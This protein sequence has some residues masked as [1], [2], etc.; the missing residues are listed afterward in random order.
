MTTLDHFKEFIADEEATH[1]YANWARDN[2]G[3]SAYSIASPSSSSE[4]GRWLTFKA[5]VL[6]GKRPTPPSLGSSQGQSLV[7]VGILYL[8]TLPPVTPPVVHP[9]ESPDKTIVPP[10]SQIVDHVGR[11]WTIK[12]GQVAVDGVVDPITGAVEQMD[13]VGG[14]IY[15]RNTPGDWYV[16]AAVVPPVWSLWS[17]G[18][19]VNPPVIPPVTPPTG[20]ADLGVSENTSGGGSKAEVLSLGVKDIREDTKASNAW[21]ASQSIRVIEIV[22]IGTAG[23]VDGTAFAYECGGNEPQQAGVDPAVWARATKKDMETI[24]AKFPNANVGITLCAIGAYYG[25]NGQDDKGNYWYPNGP[26]ISAP[27]NP[28]PWVDQIEAAAP[29]ILKL[30]KWFSV[31]PY[32]NNPF[33][34]VLDILRTQLTSHGATAPFYITECGQYDNGTPASE[35]T[36]ATQIQ[37]MITAVKKRTDTAKFI[38]YRDGEALEGDAHWG[39]VRA[40]GTHK[41][42]WDTYHAA[43]IA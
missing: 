4:L 6:A 13:Y 16:T 19:P 30:A 7:D 41:P 8:S 22:P 23:S 17:S 2:H 36:A 24:L 18:D 14:R 9:D 5:D 26:G 28:K 32:F 38:L 12:G 3:G 43:V 39:I 34:R 29:G 40:N 42:A 10:S 27:A 11:V 35:Q 37:A 15:Q 25:N 1:G 33:F 21:A 31:H 20:K